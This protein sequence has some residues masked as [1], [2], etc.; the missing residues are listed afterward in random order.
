MKRIKDLAKNSDIFKVSKGTS[1]YDTLHLMQQ[2]NIGAVLVFEKDKAQGIFSERDY[3]RKIVLENRSS[4]T[5]TIE[6]VMTTDIITISPEESL[7]YALQIMTD[8]RI[9]HL[10]IKNKENGQI[11]GIVSIGDLVKELLNFKDEKILELQ[12]YITGTP[13]KTLK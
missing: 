9:R 5:T 13:V 11:L 8:R 4:R 7:E 10:P 2:E 12:H 6:D 1:V 3:A